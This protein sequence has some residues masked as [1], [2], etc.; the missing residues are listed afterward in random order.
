MLAGREILKTVRIAGPSCTEEFNLRAGII[1]YNSAHSNFNNVPGR[2]REQLAAVDV[3]WSSGQFA[4][5][6]ATAAN[7][8]KIVV[9]DINRAGVELGRI[10]EHQRQV[11]SL[12]FNPNGGYLLLSGD[13]DGMVRLWDLRSMDRARGAITWHSRTKF[14]TN[15]DGIREVKWSPGDAVQFACGT[16]NGMIQSWDIRSN[17]AP[18][19]RINAHSETCLTI[20][21][22]PD[23][24]HLASGS[25]DRSVKVWN[26]SGDKRQKPAWFFGAPQPVA[27]L[28]WRPLAWSARAQSS[29]GWESTQLV[30]SYARFDS[31]VHLWDFR[32]PYVPFREIDRF[33]TAPTGLLWHSE[34]LLW[35]V[36]NEGI[37]TQTDIHFA[38]KIFDRRSIQA[39]DCA[40]FGEAIISLQRRPKRR[41]SSMNG[42][43]EIGDL[44]AS[45]KE[46]GSSG[47]K[48]SGSEGAADG[49]A[50][51]SLESG[52]FGS[53]FRRRPKHVID[54]KSPSKSQTSTPPSINPIASNMEAA[55]L[56][57]T[58]FRP[59]QVEAIVRNIT[60]LDPAE[61]RYLAERYIATFLPPELS[62]EAQAQGLEAR[63]EEY[64]ESNAL[65]AQ[66][67]QHYRL[68]QSWRIIRQIFMLEVR[69]RA[70]AKRKVRLLKA[71]RES[72]EQ[73]DNASHQRE[74]T[75]KSPVRERTEIGSSMATPLARPLPDSPEATS[76][77]VQLP[78]I[79]IGDEIQLSGP[80]VHF[81]EH[82]L[83]LA[84]SQDSIRHGGARWIPKAKGIS[85][86]KLSHQS[87]A[88]HDGS[89]TGRLDMN[90][91]LASDSYDPNSFQ[92]SQSSGEGFKFTQS[93][94]SP[95]SYRMTGP[96]SFDSDDMRIGRMSFEEE[97]IPSSDS[98]KSIGTEPIPDIFN[99]SS[100]ESESTP[101]GSKALMKQREQTYMLPKAEKKIPRS[102]PPIVLSS[103][104]LPTHEPSKQDVQE[105]LQNEPP[106]VESSKNTLQPS[107]EENPNFID[108]DFLPLL[109]LIKGT[110]N[111]YEEEITYEANTAVFLSLPSVMKAL[112]SSLLG[113]PDYDVQAATTL[114]LLVR[115]IFPLEVNPVQLSFLVRAYHDSLIHRSLFTDAAYLRLLVGPDPIHKRLVNTYTRD[116]ALKWTCLT[117]QRPRR[118]QAEAMPRY[119]KRCALPSAPCIVCNES[120]GGKLWAWCQSCAHGGH[121]DCMD[122]WFSLDVSGGECPVSGCGC[123][124]RPGTLRKEK[125]KFMEEEAEKKRISSLR[126]GSRPTQI[127]VEE[128]LQ[129]YKAGQ[130]VPDRGAGAI[131]LAPSPAAMAATAAA[132]ANAAVASA[133]ATA[134]ATAA[135]SAAATTADKAT[136]ATAK[137]IVVRE[138]DYDSETEDSMAVFSWGRGL[139]TGISRLDEHL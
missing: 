2:I 62:A 103:S 42:N 74:D 30:T 106:A 17:H 89:P 11:H 38:P 84:S 127:L 88:V 122:S 23:G 80:S 29:G 107:N 52:F 10:H 15:A 138:E 86:R 59:E 34:D 1:A 126:R 120:E 139:R 35:S 87:Q 124:C 58:L 37:F 7:N 63:M 46:K 19:L 8:G 65:A 81:E 118:D 98:F 50:D 77:Q 78:N 128:G 96:T 9:Y 36:G 101:E 28:R 39:L 130:V 111:L 133:S 54:A 93:T 112:L 95:E 131:P 104:L 79:E 105:P 71:S 3:K 40:H 75:L 121:M 119:C 90:A 125:L 73:A 102:A 61:F 27:K 55:M 51:D 91:G 70:T 94:P 32:R 68:A 114:L 64:F 6:I 115:Q 92:P 5:T 69:A 41:A 129:R 20:D 135:T 48:L 47:E 99:A 12:D 21:F 110:G 113:P 83:Q 13:Q 97:G 16:D 56:L 123:D 4:N 53:S 43:A 76:S 132:N 137:E 100:I 33:A 85:P 136:S 117:C 26:L 24:K 82:K 109:K 57:G 45:S 49:G 25:M 22:H 72:G 60:S 14:K 18:L 108:D 66:N 134:T 31:R 67:I 116:I 44:S